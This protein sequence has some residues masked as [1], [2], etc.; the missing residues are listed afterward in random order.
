MGSFSTD[1]CYHP[2]KKGILNRTFT[3]M[4]KSSA[5][6][7]LYTNTLLLY[8]R[9]LFTVVVGLYTSRVVLNTLGVSDYG[10]YNIVGSIVFMLAF[11]N[12]A[13][14]TATQR[15]LSYELGSKNLK[16]LNDVF[17]TSLSIHI[18]LSII[19]LIFA[20]TFGLYFLNFHL[21]IP[22]T[23]ISAANWVY[24]CSLF[25]FIWNIISVPYNSCIV[26]HERMKVF[27]YISIL[28]VSMKLVIVF[29]LLIFKTDKLIT[30]GV[31]LLCVQIIIQIIYT[32]YCRKSFPECNYHISVNKPLFKEMF[33]FIGW[34]IIGNLGYSIK[35]QVSN[36]ILNIFFGTVVN[37]AR[38]IAL[39]VNGIIWNFSGNFLM[40]V[41]PQIT[42][43]YAEN[44]INNYKKLIYTSCHFSFFLLSIITIPFI[45][46]MDYLLKLW[47]GNVPNYT[48]EF[49]LLTLITSL[50]N[51]MIIPMT[52]GIQATGKVRSLQISITTFAL[53]ES[54][55]GY[56]LLKYGGNPY[57]VMYPTVFLAILQFIV[58]LI[59]LGKII[60]KA[61]YRSF[62]CSILIKNICI[63]G[64]C[65]TTS[66]IISSL[67]PT[68]NFMTF[69]ETSAIAVII[70]VFT[71]YILGLSNKER[72]FVNNKVINL[73]YKYSR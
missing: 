39:Q 25:T 44:D 28:Q 21:N 24:Q 73:I 48:Y 10:I 42:K 66:Y 8:I 15:F 51:A 57:A 27:A 12:N 52:T 53:M 37:A 63:A 59:I 43:S 13:M 64:I 26:A 54:L 69:I 65:Y 3:F 67:F 47:L 60:G 23:R 62:I 32:I 9:M 4:T 14:I 7:R 29:L 45:I 33:S 55:L 17:C 70:T 20:E 56:L 19:I 31:L 18:V 72:L 2:L 35:D 50:I 11:L 22:E 61:I 68:K 30:Y 71:I 49:L 1:T 41:N 58:E 40:A 46:N 16:R 5:N 36:I 6:K 34:N 38:G